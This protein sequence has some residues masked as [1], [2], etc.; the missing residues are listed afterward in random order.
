[1]KVVVIMN[2]QCSGSKCE[3]RTCTL[4]DKTL[5]NKKVKSQD[6]SICPWWINSE[7]HHF[8]FW[9]YVLELSGPDGSMP[10]M[11]QSDIAELMG[12]SNTKTHFALKEAMVELIAALK[13]NKANELLEEDY[14]QL[15]DI[16]MADPIS[17]EPDDS[18]D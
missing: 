6:E 9:T 3:Y 4:T 5:N 13:L 2:S 10:E 12:W 7:I 1:M 14:E 18:Q 8:C 17:S 16:P 11:V 15:V